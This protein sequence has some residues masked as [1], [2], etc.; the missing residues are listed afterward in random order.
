MQGLGIIEVGLSVL[1]LDAPLE[2]PGALGKALPAYEV[3]LRGEDGEPLP[4]GQPGEFHVRGP[5]LLDAY[6]VPWNPDPLD[7]GFFASGD[8]VVLETFSVET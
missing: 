5:G 1:N 4:D 7:D 6:L 2:K 3:E 8:L